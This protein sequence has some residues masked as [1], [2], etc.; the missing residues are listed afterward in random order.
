[1]LAIYRD[2]GDGFY[3]KDVFERRF[4]EDSEMNYA[5]FRRTAR[6]MQELG[7]LTRR[8]E[9]AQKWERGDFANL[10][11]AQREFDYARA[12]ELLD[13]GEVMGNPLLKEL[14]FTVA[15]EDADSDIREEL[16][17]AL[18]V[19]DEEFVEE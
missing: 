10:L 16:I 17:E 15:V 5:T 4:G 6:G 9:K 14:V 3:L 2:T 8:S 11:V 13:M 12:F 7:W 18:D 1:M 19:D